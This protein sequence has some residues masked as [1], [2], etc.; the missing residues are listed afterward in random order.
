MSTP[1]V[2]THPVHVQGA[3]L[4]V[5][6]PT[7]FNTEPGHGQSV[8]FSPFSAHRLACAAGSDFGLS[9]IALFFLEFLLMCWLIWGQTF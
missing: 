5:Y 4:P 3:A 2:G 8:K 1:A 6:P 7:E 9:G